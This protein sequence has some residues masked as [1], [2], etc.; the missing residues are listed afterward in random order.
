MA[1]EAFLLLAEK[2]EVEGL[3]AEKPCALIKV[4]K[5]IQTFQGEIMLLKKKVNIP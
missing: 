1:C 4:Q 3:Y 5:R 2:S